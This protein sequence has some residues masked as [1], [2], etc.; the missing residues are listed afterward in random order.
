MKKRKQTEKKCLMFPLK[1]TMTNK[2]LGNEWSEF[3]GQFM[4]IDIDLIASTSFNSWDA[5][6]GKKKI[7]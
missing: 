4:M 6:F 7:A 5:A 2:R 3:K 1:G